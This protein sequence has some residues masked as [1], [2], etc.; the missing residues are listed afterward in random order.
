MFTEFRIQNLPYLI[1]VGMLLSACGPS[2]E[3]VA[4]MTAA[5]W[6]ETPTA[7]ATATATSAPTS[8]NTLTPTPAYQS[9]LEV[10]TN[11]AA[12]GDGGNSWGGHQT[13]IVRTQDGVFTA[14][15]VEGGGYF[16]REWRL[17][18]RQDDG[19]WPVVAQGV[20]GIGDQAIFRLTD[21]VQRSHL[22]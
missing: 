6:T 17:A 11:S 14:Y 20:A 13:R 21:L 2:T 4:T 5:V 15:T 18:W 10:V 8:T 12:T 7:T 3:E 19:T 1:F 9:H 16:S 22:T